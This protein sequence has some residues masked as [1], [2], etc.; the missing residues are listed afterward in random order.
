VRVLRGWPLPSTGI[1]FAAEPALG[2]R[3][4]FT[5]LRFLRLSGRN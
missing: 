2:A 4:G 1:D 3:S 5:D